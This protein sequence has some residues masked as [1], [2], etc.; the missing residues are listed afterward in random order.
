[1]KAKI[2][3]LAA[4]LALAVTQSASAQTTYDWTGTT[5]GNMTDS[6]NWTPN[7]TPTGT[8]IAQWNAASY[9]NAPTANGNLTVGELLFTGNNTAGMAFGAGTGTLTLNGVSG[10]GIQVDSGS[11][12]VNTG[13][14]K[15][16]L[17]A[18][19]SWINNSTSALTVNGTITNTGN[20][21]AFTL[22][23]GG[24]GNTT[25]A[26][27]ISNGGTLGTLALTKTGTGTLTLNGTNTFTGGTTINASSGTIVTNA[28]SALGTGAVAVGSGSTLQLNTNN[29]SMT[30]A[31]TITGSG[32][33]KLNFSGSGLTNSLINGVTGF[34]GTIQ[35]SNTGSNGNKWSATN[36]GVIPAALIIDSGSQLYL[37]GGMTT[38]ANGITVTGI[39]NSEN[40]G[41]I[42]LGGVLG[43]NISL[44]GNTTIGAEGGMLTG[45]I[46]SGASGT[47]VLTSGGSASSTLSVSGS[48]GGGNG[49]LA[50]VQNRTGVTLILSGNNSYT[51]GT[52]V[53]S[54]ALVATSA[55]ALG[56]AGS[57]TVTVSANTTLSY[58]ASSDAPLAIGGNLAITSGGN[59]TLGGSIGST[60]TSASIT[61][62]GNASISNAAHTV[63]IYGINGV[64]PASGN[65]TLISGGAGSSLNPATAPTLGRVYNNT[66][67][68]VGALSSTANTLD[69]AVT[70][71]TAL[72][73]AY[74][75]GNLTGATAVWAASNGSSASNWS[76]TNGGAVQALVPG[77]STDVTIAA[78]TPA[79]DA[80]PSTLGANMAIKSLTVADTTNGLA[81][82]ADGYTLTITPADPA[83]GIVINSGVAASS[84]GA[85]LAL[86]AAQTWT[87]N[88][89]NTF[90]VSAQTIT[91]GGNALAID[92]TGNINISGAIMGG[93]GS[94]T[95]NGTG[96]LTL[97][98]V[99]SYTGG[100]TV[101]T[102]VLDFQN[103][104]AKPATGTTTVAAGATLALGVASSGNFFTSADVDSLFA[105]TLA[106]VTNDAASI[107]GID[108]TAASFTYST[109]IGATSRGL[110]KVGSN[111]LVLT[112]TN[113]YTG[114]TLIY[115]GSLQIDTAGAIG[116]TS[117]ITVSA[118]NSS[119][120][121]I[122][123]NVTAGSGKSLTISG[124]GAGGF[125]G[126]LSTPGTYTGSSEWQGNVTIASATGTRIG[127]QQG[128]LTVSGVIGE[129]FPGSELLI[130]N[131]TGTTIL[132]A[133]NTFTGSTQTFGGLL[134]VSAIGN[135]GAYSPLGTN[136]TI[137]LGV[138]TT[139]G[140]L[141]YTGSGE[142]T[143]KVIDQS[144]TTAG[145]TI[146]QSGTGLLAF[147]SNLTATGAGNKTLT[148]QGSTAGNGEISGVIVDNSGTNL[149][150]V[151]KLGSGTW[152]LSGANTFGGTT[153]VSAGKLVVANVS[154]LG[155][156]GAFGNRTTIG[157]GGTLELATDAPINPEVLDVGST[158][159]GTVIVNRATAGAGFTQTFG[160]SLLGNANLSVQAGANVTSGAATLAFQGVSLSA[161]AAG[162]TTLNP[163]TAAISI[164]GGVSSSSNFAKTLNL[165]G[166]NASNA[167]SGNIS[168]GTNVVS[169]TKTNSS[170][171]TLSGANTYT[172]TTG[173]NGGSLVLDYSSQDNSKLSNT[174]ALTLAGGTLVLSGGNHT[175]TVL[176]TSLTAATASSVTR[177]SGAAVLQMNA[178]TRNS[179]STL[180]FGAD[181]IATTD[182][183]NSNGTLGGWA[184]VGGSTWATNSLNA[185]D[186]P[187]T[188]LTSY[189]LTS[190]A[191]NTA[192]N[193]L[194]NNISADSSQTLDAAA[195]PNSLRFN[196]ANAHTLTLQGNN[197]VSSGGIL[198]T[199]AV[200]SNASTITGGNLAGPVSSDLIVIQNNTSGNLTIGSVI[201]NNTSTNL[202]KSGPGE[203]VL[204]GANTYNG[205]TTVS[206]GI[207]TLA[208]N[209]TAA[210][211]GITVSST[212]G[213]DAVLNIS[214]GTYA[215]GANTF[216]VGNAPGTAATGT[217]NQTGGSVTFSGASNALLIG[218]S[219]VG[220][221]A[222]TG[223]YNLSGGS[224]TTNSTSANR[225]IIIGVNN[226]VAGGAFNL[227]GTGVLNMTAATGGSDTSVLAI[228][229]YESAGSGATVSFT[230]TGGTA[231]VAILSIGGNG[232]TG[233]GINATM[234][235][236]GGNFTANTFPRLALGNTN[237]AVITIDG[238]VDV[239][240]PAFPTARGT[241][242]TATLNFD[243]GTLRPLS[244]NATYISGLTN[245]F[246]KSGGARFDVASG[247]DITVPQALLTH[248]TSLGGGL[249]KDGVGS[250]T[251]SGTNTYTGATT[252]TAGTLIVSGGG[253]IN[254]SA[255]I[256]VV[257][258]ATLTNNT[259]TALTPALAL[260]EGS[261]LSG[262]GNFNP[263][264]MTL[265]GN[266][267]DGFTPV[268]AGST[269]TKAGALTFTL[270][271]VT[272]GTYSLFT[273][274][275]SSSFTSVNVG[276]SPLTFDGGDNLWKGNV[277]GFDYAFS[278]VANTLSVAAIPEPKTWALIG[279]GLGFTLFRFSA[280][281]RRL[282][283]LSGRID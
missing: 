145:G 212:A 279:L 168:N 48:I 28:A 134:R 232:G 158:V 11:G 270:S 125:F 14:A 237:S 8:D 133:N 5:N 194:N 183:L 248:G 246:I 182:T 282:K 104:L 34:T 106:N 13:S 135:T 243:G 64:T 24:S 111:T 58:A 191:G 169:L 227:S 127:T 10:V 109:S 30:Y 90:T 155:A 7:V 82:N 150:S 219:G 224:I 283:R 99:N 218:N 223:V 62:T 79:L 190:V 66:N 4:V 170:T 266:L 159:T 119:A 69:V 186:S 35:L 265:T 272:D 39:G 141:V 166:T 16:A 3:T 142:T 114:D 100:T 263:T 93:A 70:S 276:G 226:G 102:G 180:N 91:N 87:N 196:D 51:G 201:Q 110:A 268:T 46:F 122:G 49:T 175:E 151:A 173:V 98:G 174:S 52:T 256:T 247:K 176:S 238:T 254:T 250:L 214:S 107:V 123:G 222:N 260:G 273:G 220:A 193:Y 148:L 187:V 234:T 121:V 78:T 204:T 55:N 199:S 6:T 208:G 76:E 255:S 209:R 129:A 162:T 36:L 41:A 72:T 160:S 25:L 27:V 23:S 50:V 280:R 184:T 181:S 88:S 29:A 131:N 116:G 210:S 67:F 108:T 44:T 189:T 92:G 157:N 38:I 113:A 149:T 83:A 153:T 213:A 32:L 19:Q 164:T 81:L 126:A 84:I 225:G 124:V 101:N 154:A 95:K 43:G 278:D 21:T 97:S 63:N 68:T 249:T 240:L 9:T 211:G 221:I 177:S 59:T 205:T 215:L 195:T 188:G 261:T 259:A 242:S 37:P 18:N 156:Y 75:M 94:L 137:R 60:A 277:G 61:V 198:V 85:K 252:V 178:I 56:G 33:L 31:N 202:L 233:T 197:T 139:S 138:T 179:G 217:V 192:A 140:N 20:A 231:N 143:D 74:W 264:A 165:D 17:A 147:T 203:L 245:A 112:G 244:A 136:A 163:T 57:G 89:A 15:F 47:Q 86:G 275:P 128:N 239:T 274:S 258:G 117:N 53:T 103:T 144:G 65:Y 241:G 115:G 40:R 54:G 73:T 235:L 130:R 200:G 171:W 2:L 207:L 253:T 152:T 271:G 146:D 118:S 262:T 80:N 77:T 185:T 105:G 1:M 161:G 96:V 42:R 206:G 216:T 229:R 26:G 267:A 281:S 167:I 230:Q 71:Q 228:G 269:L 12:A 236:T 120:L 172:G 132:T 257:T 22:T 251:L 45:N